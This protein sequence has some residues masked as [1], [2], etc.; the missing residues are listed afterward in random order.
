MPSPQA[1]ERSKRTRRSRCTSPSSTRSPRTTSGGGRA[2]PSGPTWRRRDR[3]SPATTSRSCRPISASTTCVCRR[4][5]RR[6][7]T[8]AGAHGI[9][10]FCYW[11]Y[12]FAGRRLLERPFDEVL[13]SGEPDFPFCLA[14]ANQTWTDDLDRRP[15]P[16][17]DRADV[18]RARRSRAPLLRGAAGI[19][20]S[21]VHPRRRASRCSSSTARTSF[22]DARRVRRPVARTRARTRASPVCT[23]SASAR[24]DGTRQTTVSTPTRC[25]GSTDRAQPSAPRPVRGRLESRRPRR[26][27]T[28]YAYARLAQRPR[29]ASVGAASRLPMVVPN[30]DNTPRSARTASC[31]NGCTPELFEGSMH[32]AS[33]RCRASRPT[34]ASCS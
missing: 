15:Q 1:G 17:A 14:W 30:W 32:Q 6:R 22:P 5:A 20:R 25:P 8:L 21:A 28:R 12:W 23:S 2:S 7:P 9:E 29:A 19:P 31:S 24:A 10:A 26:V 4:R 11:H 3:C 18:S 13:Q 16:R 27:P 34:N 33:P